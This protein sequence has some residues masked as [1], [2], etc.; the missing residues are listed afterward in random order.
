[1]FSLFKKEMTDELKQSFWMDTIVMKINDKIRGI[2][3][4]KY[5]SKN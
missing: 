2:K 3:N 5:K 4:G 1:M